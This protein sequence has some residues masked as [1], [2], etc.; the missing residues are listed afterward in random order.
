MICNACGTFLSDESKFCNN[1]GASVGASEPKDEASPAG[2]EK[3]Q[4]ALSKEE[5]EQLI[6][7]LAAAGVKI[8]IKYESKQDEAASGDRYTVLLNAVGHNRPEVLH[9]VREVTALPLLNAQNLINVVPV[10]VR[11]GLSKREAEAI[12]QRLVGAG[13]AARVEPTSKAARLPPVVESNFRPPEL[14]PAA[15]PS[16]SMT[17]GC[18]AIIVIIFLLFLCVAL[19]Q[20]PSRVY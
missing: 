19:G 20:K 11:E 1:C 10:I 12:R 6:Q 14:A 15:A 3:A 2:E 13:A 16:N 5:A 17:S 4:S 9:I 7:K 8:E 18:V